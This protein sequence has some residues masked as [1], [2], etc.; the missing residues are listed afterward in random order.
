MLVR[1]LLMVDV[2]PYSYSLYQRR[3]G[4]VALAVAIND[5]ATVSV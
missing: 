4:P 2:D 1:N 3:G 5:M